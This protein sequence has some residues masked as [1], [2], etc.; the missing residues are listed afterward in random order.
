[1]YNLT[2]YAEAGTGSDGRVA[3]W[4]VENEDTG[5]AIF[6]QVLDR[7]TGTWLDIR[8]A[9]DRVRSDPRNVDIWNGAIKQPIAGRSAGSFA[10]LEHLL[11][12]LS[13][14]GSALQKTA[15][16]TN[17]TPDRWH[18]DALVTEAG[19]V[20]A[21]GPDGSLFG[22]CSVN[23]RGPDGSIFEAD[24]H[25]AVRSLQRQTRDLLDLFFYHDHGP[26]GSV[27]TNDDIII[28]RE[29]QF[30]M[31]ARRGDQIMIFVPQTENTTE[32]FLIGS[33]KHD[34]HFP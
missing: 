13:N 29:R 21:F 12:M 3:G 4:V 24:I 19:F 31:I 32:Q 6:G 8:V 17:S 25:K 33:A 28:A 30:G 15:A 18:P 7:P 34:F 5:E 9:P 16:S 10:P 2:P 14:P 11:G 1:M 20:A 26:T 27:M 22:I 23:G